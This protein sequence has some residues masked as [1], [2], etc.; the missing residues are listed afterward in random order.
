[1]H[2]PAEAS[3]STGSSAMV[4]YRPIRQE[5]EIRVLEI[6]PGMPDDP[7]LGTL[8][9]CSIEF[10]YTIPVERTK[11]NSSI[12][13]PHALS[14]DNLNTPMWYT[15]LSY[16]WGEPIFDATI[17]CDG[18]EKQITRTLE[19][20]LRQFRCPNESIV[21]WIDQ[22]CINQDD[23]VEK[24]L[25]I[26]LMSDIYEL[27]YSTIIWIG[28]AGD[29]TPEAMELVREISYKWFELPEPDAKDE[30]GRK[31]FTRLWTIQ[32]VVLSAQPWI[33]CGEHVLKFM[34]LGDFCE[35][36]RD[37]TA[38]VD[39][40]GL[41]NK[42]PELSVPL[43]HVPATLA[44]QKAMC[45]RGDTKLKVNRLPL[46]VNSNDSRHAQAFDLRDK[47]YGMLGMLNTSLSN[48]IM[49]SYEKDYTPGMAF[50]NAA[51]ADITER[52]GLLCDVLFGV[53]HEPNS[54]L[55]DLP[56]WVPD[57]SQ[58][59]VSKSLAVGTTTWHMY[60]ASLVDYGKRQNHTQVLRPDT[61]ELLV[62]AWVFDTIDGLSET[63][64]KPLM[65]IDE[66]ALRNKE[67]ASWV[68]LTSRSA[69][70]EVYGG[71]V[72]EA[73][74]RTL[75][76]DKNGDGRNTAPDSFA[77]IFSLLLDET[78]GRSP[79]L[80]G[81]THSARQQRPAGRGKLDLASLKSR[82]PAA[83][84]SEVQDALKSAMDVACVINEI[85]VPFLIRRREDGR[86]DLLGECYVHGVMQGQV[87]ESGKFEQE[88][89]V[90]A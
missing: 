70:C 23:K 85:H 7:L 89:I 59:R 38:A 1:M 72:F 46:V 43:W 82:K 56:S 57:W 90:L 34:D 11:W 17:L 80:L 73:F 75:V 15:A 18:V 68:D 71:S 49:V 77:E 5:Y 25:Q 50:C 16:T 4:I 13:H 87:V 53:D 74:W 48:R 36:L 62:H 86:Y 26:R 78:T 44:S 20:A 40:E 35:K 55:P 83:T 66:P 65:D 31:W 52:S 39:L 58:P 51:Y 76:G 6:H 64:T 32:E 84:L 41:Y 47:I 9:H 27:A 79:S 45:P 69:T 24:V 30:A 12:S 21:M 10:K 29:N 33:M 2:H 54:K 63:C 88:V 42:K 19:E 22:I 37:T 28:P 8:H 14:Q 81:Q 60:N 61:M 3:S 67:L